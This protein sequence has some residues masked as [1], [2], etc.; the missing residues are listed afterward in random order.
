VLQHIEYALGHI[1]YAKFN[2]HSSERFKIG[3]ANP[4]SITGG[5]MQWDSAEKILTVH[6]NNNKVTVVLGK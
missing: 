5:T 2:A 1:A 6:S 4:M 3:A